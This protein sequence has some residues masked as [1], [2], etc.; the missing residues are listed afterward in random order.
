MAGQI[1]TAELLVRPDAAHFGALEV[2]PDVLSWL[3][4]QD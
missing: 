4:R 2:V 3:I 1:P